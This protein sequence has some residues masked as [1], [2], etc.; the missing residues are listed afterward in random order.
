MTHILIVEDYPNLQLVYKTALEAEGYEVWQAADG[1]A[2]LVIAQ[3][4]EPDLILLDLLLPREGGLEFLREF[5][6][7]QHPRVKVVV[8]SNMASPE[9][10]AEA[11]QLGATQYLIKAN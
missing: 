9:L 7:K 3:E 10:Y 5:D 11:K 8:F 1:E 4:H 2:A 6:T